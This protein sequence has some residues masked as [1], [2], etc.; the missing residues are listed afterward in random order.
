MNSDIDI[1]SE[2]ERKRPL[3]SEVNRLYGDNTLIRKL[4]KWSPNYGV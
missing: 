4:T 2:E 3:N 1:I